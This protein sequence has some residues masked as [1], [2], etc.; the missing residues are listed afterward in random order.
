METKTEMI[1]YLTRVRRH[2]HACPELYYHEYKTSEFVC[3]ELKSM[4]IKYRTYATAVVADIKGRGKGGTLAFR[5]DMDALPITETG[6]RA[7]KE[8]FVSANKGV[9]HACGHDGHTA[10]L[11]ALARSL[12][13]RP[14]AVDVRLIFQPAEEHGGGAEALIK[15]G[16]LKGVE[17]IFGLH[18]SPEHD[19]GVIATDGGAIFA[20]VVDFYLEF[21]G[22]SGHCAEPYK[23][24]DAIFA[25]NNLYTRAK[26]LITNYE[27]C[28]FNVGKMEGGTANNII[29]DYARLD[30]TFRYFS[31]EAKESFFM[32]FQ[33]ILNDIYNK[34]GAD[35]RLTV[36]SA[37]PPLINSTA[38]AQM[39]RKTFGELV[40]TAQPKYT[41]EDFAF[42]LKEVPGVFA[43]LG[44]KDEDFSHGLHTPEFDFDEAALVTGVEYFRRIADNGLV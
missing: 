13:K 25:A 41:A 23:A 6:A 12:S 3:A 16:V 37:Y 14:P 29:S 33:D 32:R 11:L 17:A 2:L 10:M 40:V 35:H 42:Y 18:L 22:K 21:S 44:I 7:I 36:I 30:C 34:I 15:E 1:E 8:G 31:D 20:G 4:G 39:V 27:G 43:W 26:E 9:M 38:V 5:A 28:L 19:K 24:I